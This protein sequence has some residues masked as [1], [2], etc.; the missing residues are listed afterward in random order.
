MEPLKTQVVNIDTTLPSITSD[1]NP[2]PNSV[3]WNDSPVKVT[4]T[5]SDPAGIPDGTCPAPVTLSKNGADQSVNASVTDN[6]GN[7]NNIIVKNINVDN[8]GPTITA[9]ATTGDK[10]VYTAGT[11]TN[12][13]VVVTF[14]CQDEFSGIAGCTAPV[15]SLRRGGRPGSVRNGQ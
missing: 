1:V 11:W 8:L 3:G 5:C 2:V 4:F 12:K 6:A 14:T 7:S 15:P 9:K 13:P 10:A